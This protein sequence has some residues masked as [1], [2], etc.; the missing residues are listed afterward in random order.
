MC[1]SNT[2]IQG[3][4]EE[5]MAIGATHIIIACDT[6]S[7]EDYPVFIMPNQNVDEKLNYYSRN[8]NMQSYHEVIELKVNNT[9]DTNK[10][11]MKLRT[12]IKKPVRFTY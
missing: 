7:Y 4:V 1:N 10:F 2:I 12:N 5:G 9:N 6:F 11:H 3:W 8:N